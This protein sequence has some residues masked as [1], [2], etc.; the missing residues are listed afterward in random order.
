MS[1]LLEMTGQRFGRLTVIARAQNL[2]HKAAWQC[3][4]DCGRTVAIRGW[5]L[6]SG[7]SQSCGCWKRDRLRKHGMKNT[8]EYVVWQAMKDRCYNPRRSAYKDYGGRGIRI[9]ERWRNDFREFYK[10]MGPR[11]KGT[12]LDRI[13]NDGDYE[14]GN[15]RWAT[16]DMQA[17]N[18]R[19]TRRFTHQGED[20]CV[21]EWARRIGKSYSAVR[22]WYISGK[23]AARLD[24]LLPGVR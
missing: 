3:L 20:L 12:S 1:R 24:E 8:P 11:P 2:D 19:K 7:A 18:M 23:L 4:C 15:C 14:P 5:L 17:R 13:N 6:R 16:K 10:D 9:C 22:D 21:A